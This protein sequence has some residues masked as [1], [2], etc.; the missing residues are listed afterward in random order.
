MQP[1]RSN[2]DGLLAGHSPHANADFDPSN[3]REDRLVGAE[4]LAVLGVAP[5]PLGATPNPPA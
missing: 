1:D 3:V 2:E 5:N 4:F